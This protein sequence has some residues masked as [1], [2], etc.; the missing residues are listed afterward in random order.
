MAEAAP[1]GI[2]VVDSG[3]HIIL[4]D[5]G[6]EHL[7]GY[8]RRDFIG[9]PVEAVILPTFQPSDDLRV[10]R[11]KNGVEIQLESAFVRAADDTHSGRHQLVHHR[12]ELVGELTDT[13]A[14]EFDNVL[15]VLRTEVS[16]LGIDSG[17]GQN[18]AVAR[19]DNALDRA[20]ELA[21]QLVTIGH[22]ARLS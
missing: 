20:T 22:I 12:P 21:R 3:G 13:V 5:R 11:C 1:D 14:H 17:L 7:L 6:L 2:F 15:T 10:A 18:E 19:I 8:A 16:L 9:L 4:V